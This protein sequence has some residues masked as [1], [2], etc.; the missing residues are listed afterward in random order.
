MAASGFRDTSRLAAC[1]VTMMLD[2][3]VTN[4]PAILDGLGRYRA[5][6]DALTAL[7]ENG[8]VDGL[9]AFLQAAKA[10][11]SLPLWARK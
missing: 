2:I 1:D 11:R 7:L 9:A 5:E 6:L 4:R 3:L 10:R 8:N